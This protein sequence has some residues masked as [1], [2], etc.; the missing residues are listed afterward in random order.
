MVTTIHTKKSTFKD[1]ETY[2][3][4]KERLFHSL[5]INMIISELENNDIHV[6]RKDIQKTYQ[7]NYDLNKTIDIFDEKYSEQLDALALK[8]E[9]FDD[10]ALAILIM[11]VIEHDFDRHSVCDIVYIADDINSLLHSEIEYQ[12]LLK[13]T[14]KILKRLNKMKKYRKIDDLQNEFMPYGIDLEQFFTRVFQEIEGF[15]NIQLLK[16]L[17]ALIIEL[18]D[19]YQL[20]LRYVEIQIDIL[21]AIALLDQNNI[22]QDI[23]KIVKT[24]PDYQF[25]LYYKILNSLQKAKNKELVHKYLQEVLQ[26][27]PKNEEQADLLDVIKEIFQ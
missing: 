21:S 22:D 18:L 8:N 3:L 27:S 11:K 13:Q 19:H 2:H 9:V 25:I 12:D 17:Y 24:Y 6:L 4:E 14:K 1:N 16:Q 10:D 5:T 20:S 7:S 26:L 15:E 23:Q